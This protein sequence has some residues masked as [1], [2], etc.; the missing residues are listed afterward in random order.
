G[1]AFGRT[2]WTTA[3]RGTVVREEPWGRLEAL[4]DGIWALIS[5]P[6]DGDRT[7]LCNGGIVAGLDGV[8]LIEGFATSAGAQWMAAEARRLTGRAPTH[9]VLTHFHGDHT[10]GIGGYADGGA[11]MRVTAVTRG[12]VLQEDARRSAADGAVRAGLLAEAELM[13]PAG[14]TLI[15]LGGRAVRMIPREGHTPSDVTVEVDDPS[16]VFC[17]DLVWNRMFPNYRDA[18]PSRLGRDVRALVR[19]R[20]TRYVPGH[21]PL[22]DAGDLQRYVDLIDDVEVH[23]RRAIER[24]RPVAA[25]AAEYRVPEALGEWIMF[26]PRYYEVAFGAWERELK[27][28]PT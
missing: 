8:L 3:S 14:E 25:A 6:L 17:G 12:L 21:G 15:D 4:G 13:D 11:V 27:Q 19:T 24:G 22:A 23:A 5:T 10:G 7:T 9:V 20:E 28:G 18:I 26:S 16:V 2:A 1:P